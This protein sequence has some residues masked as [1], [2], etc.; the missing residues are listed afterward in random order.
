MKHGI[1]CVY[2]V[3][4]MCFSV[5]DILEKIKECVRARGCVPMANNLYTILKQP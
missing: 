4:D 2:A 5:L 3:D 1:V